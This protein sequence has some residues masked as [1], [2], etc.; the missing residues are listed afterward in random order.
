[1]SATHLL[2]WLSCVHHCKRW[3][4]WSRIS[5]FA[6][7]L[8]VLACRE[9]VHGQDSYEANS[10]VVS[11]LFQEPLSNDILYS[12]PVS[13]VFQD[14]VAIDAVHSP[15]VSYLFEE[16]LPTDVLTSFSSAPVHYFFNVG[17]GTTPLI[18]R[19]KVVDSSGHPLAGVTV[20]AS[21]L[22]VALGS[23][24]TAADGSYEL[25]SLPSGVYHFAARCPSFV[26]DRR[27][28]GLASS[29]AHQNFLLSPMPDPP[30]E[31]GTARKPTPSEIPPVGP[32]GSQLMVFD[33]NVGQF[34]SNVALLDTNKMTVVLTHGWIPCWDSGG[35]NDWPA[36]FAKMLS[37]KVDAIS[38]NKPVN[39]VGWDWGIAAKSCLPPAEKTSEQGAGLGR[40]LHIALGSNYVGNIHFIGHSLGT[41]VNASAATYLQG[42]SI[43]GAKGAVPAWPTNQMQM[44]L[45]DEAEIATF[46][47]KRA[48]FAGGIT[49]LETGSI[50]AGV[51]EDAAVGLA[52]YKSPLP[53]SF[54]WAENYM[55]LVGL[56]HSKAVNVALQRGFSF[57]RKDLDAVL[58]ASHDLNTVL[59]AT[60]ITANEF[61]A[62]LDVALETSPALYTALKDAILAAHGYPMDWYGPTIGSPTLS[63]LGFT[64][65]FE[66]SVLLGSEF[67][68]PGE[69]F[70]PG[71]IWHQVASPAGEHQLE[72]ATGLSELPYILHLPQVLS[73]VVEGAGAAIGQG[74]AIGE[75]VVVSTVGGLEKAGN[76]AVNVIE[77]GAVTVASGVNAV[78]NN[79]ENSIENAFDGVVDISSHAMLSLILSSSSSSTPRNRIAKDTGSGGGSN[80]PPYVWFPVFIPSDAAGMTFDYTLA[81]DPANDQLAV[82]L[83]GT[84]VFSLALQFEQTNVM[85]V[86]RLI[87]VSAN[88]GTTNEFFFGITGSSSTNCT[89]NIR[90]IRFYTLQPPALAVDNSSGVSVISWPSSANG[91]AL[92]STTNLIAS[93]W[94]TITNPPVLFAGRFSLTIATTDVTRFFR[95]GNR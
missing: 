79:A 24:V 57:S 59:I 40:T 68:R 89:V 4:Q 25:P 66:A 72:R 91:Y 83:N 87:D 90:N 6:R 8:G 65:S 41:L 76:V 80:T 12:P 19:G 15:V 37:Y 81:G 77:T 30:P 47:G 56:S 10:P 14:T 23:A 49:I 75:H 2:A 94:T 44:T 60:L 78:V 63:S 7:L 43:G 35:I 36:N 28:V 27:V 42:K 1:M 39:I 58:N 55:S 45:F 71:A 86:S 82:G 70:A 85:S 9:A 92:E 61:D 73:D 3:W 22:N 69:D 17:A 31:K 62:A 46:A 33:A 53:P 16:A 52:N 95:L 34:T 5:L 38:T 88:A 21:I 74:V 84:N 32:E 54:L 13:Y 51:A 20:T 64:N 67:P 48:I 93:N 18:V 50:L 11:Y 26:S 29:T